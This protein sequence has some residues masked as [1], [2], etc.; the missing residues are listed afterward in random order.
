MIHHGVSFVKDLEPWGGGEP[1]N[2]TRADAISLRSVE[3]DDE[4][5]LLRVYAGTREPERRVVYWEDE[6]WAAFVRV[7]YEAQRSHYEINFPDA[8]HQVVLRNGAP[9]G[10]I[11]VARAADEIRLLDIAILPEHRGC[12]IGTHL[13]RGLQTDARA[14]GVP[15]RHSV[16]HD[17][18]GA[19]RLYERLGFVAVETQGLHTLMEWSPSEDGRAPNDGDPLR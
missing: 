16:E 18:D 11:W 15:L 10:R 9:I 3:T 8:E 14:A 1:V 6:E 17:N 5:L 12:G 7:Q 13:I 2:R 19:R 4:A